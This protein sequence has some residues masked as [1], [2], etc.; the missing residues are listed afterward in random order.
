[1]VK[2][3][4]EMVSWV[5]VGAQLREEEKEQE[6]P[7]GGGTGLYFDKGVSYTDVCNFQSSLNC[8]LMICASYCV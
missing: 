1:M 3:T 7:Y 8:T 6:K 5:V 2:E 4:G